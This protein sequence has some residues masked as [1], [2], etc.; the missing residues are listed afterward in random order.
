M[1]ADVV[2]GL[3]RNVVVQPGYG[4]RGAEKLFEVRDWR[5]G[6]M[7]ADRHDWLSAFSGELCATLAIEQAMRLVAPP[8]ATWLR[9]LLAE[10]A[11]IHS[12]LSFLSVLLDGDA[13]A[14]LWATVDA[15][16]DAVLAWSGNRIHPMLNRVGGLAS[17]IPGGWQLPL[18]DV[19]RIADLCEQALGA[20]ERYRDLAT[21]DANACRAYGLSGP[22]GRAAGLDLDRR[23]RGYLAYSDVFQ[24]APTR[25][26]G[27]GHARLA[28][29]VDE[30][31]TSA[32]MADALLAGVADRPGEVSVRLAR[33]L[34]VPEG[35]HWAEL[36]APWGIAGSLLVSRGGATPWRLAL[37]T[38]SFANLSA[39]GQAL[40]GTP[41]T[42][43]ADAVATVG[44][45]VGDADK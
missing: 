27:D 28:V 19:L 4:H 21:L 30:L 31:R 45:G 8:R 37:R 17:D 41:E 2:D 32:A 6:I 25:T 11:R 35:E 13:A 44:Y 23:A 20:T 40:E 15:M 10:T 42:Q 43:I 1:E 29:L 18:D 33:R 34:K 14:Q 39:L 24:P 22:V 5:A 16:R 3:W 12:H 36:E 26:A 38:P 7:L 9:T